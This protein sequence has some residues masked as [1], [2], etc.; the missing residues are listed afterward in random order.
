MTNEQEKLWKIRVSQL[1]S[2]VERFVKQAQQL[3]ATVPQSLTDAI[4]AV[5]ELP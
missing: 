5:K 2:E 3:T 4:A 1:L